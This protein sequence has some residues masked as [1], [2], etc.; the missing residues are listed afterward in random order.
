MSSGWLVPLML[1]SAQAGVPQAKPASILHAFREEVRQRMAESAGTR[2]P[3]PETVG[4]KLLDLYRRLETAAVLPKLERLRLLRLVGTRLHQVETTLARR[5]ERAEKASKASRGGAVLH[6][7]LPDNSRQGSNRNAATT[8]GW[9]LVELIRE[10]VDPDT[11][12]VNGG[13]GSMFYHHPVLGLVV[14]QTGEVHEHVGE[15]LR[16]AR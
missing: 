9:A 7:Q 12:D 5:L 13:E 15:T 11:W 10:T 14:R 4:P 16:G 3:E 1:W 2:R 6:Q 8:R